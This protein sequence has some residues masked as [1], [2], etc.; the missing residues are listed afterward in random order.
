MELWESSLRTIAKAS[1]GTMMVVEQTEMVMGVNGTQIMNIYVED[2]MMTTLMLRN[3]VVPVEVGN[4]C[5]AA[6]KLMDLVHV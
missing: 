6:K 4:V 1:V 3:Y 2:T 5:Q